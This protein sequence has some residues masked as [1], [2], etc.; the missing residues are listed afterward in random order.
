MTTFIKMLAAALAGVCIGLLT[1]DMAIVRDAGFGSAAAGPWTAWLKRGAP[2]P[3][4]YTRAAIARFGEIPLGPGEG[5]S[6]VAGADSAGARFSGACDYRIVG[7]PIATRFW[8]LSLLDPAGARP[9]NGDARAVFTSQEILRSEDGAFEIVAS[10]RAR[11]GNWIAAPETGAFMLM[12]S[13]YDASVGT[14]AGTI[15]TAGLPR[16]EKGDCR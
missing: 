9:A 8:T 10:A 6:F 14:T 15:A 1:V 11:A 7:K 3:D 13:L 4:P 12:L 2:D 16:I 5:L